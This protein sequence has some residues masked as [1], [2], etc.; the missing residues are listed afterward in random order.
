MGYKLIVAGGREFN[1]YNKLRED[2]ES[3]NISDLEIVCGKARGADSL[4]E[5][6]ARENNLVLHEFPAKWDS[7][8]KR[9]GFVRNSEMADFADGC[10]CFWDAKSRGT[11][12]MIDLAR[13]KGID[14]T[15]KLY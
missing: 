4:G 1:D 15:I 11:K 2:I 3:L 14:I 5:R 7:L 10:I 12:H 13:K 6:Y 8:G 9:A